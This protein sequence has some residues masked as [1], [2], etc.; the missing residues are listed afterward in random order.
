MTKA[1]D[2]PA[3][4]LRQHFEVRDDGLWR[5]AYTDARGH[6]RPEKKVRLKANHHTGYCTVKFKGRR[7]A[8][9]RLVWILEIGDIPDG[10]QLD[11]RNGDKLD[12]CLENLR[13]VTHREN[14]QNKA[15]HRATGRC[16]YRWHKRGKKWEARVNI[17]GKII[18]LGYFTN[19]NEAQKA[20]NIA[21]ELIEVYT[22]NNQFR[23]LVKSKITE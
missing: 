11:H 23:E 8:Y 3:E 1:K 2:Y 19:E 17:N 13:L 9:H 10:L 6:R 15:F 12:N 7:I 4:F 22:N 5:L 18:S 16:G 14:N 20:Y 21:C